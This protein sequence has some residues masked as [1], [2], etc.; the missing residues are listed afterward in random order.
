MKSMRE[1]ER[2]RGR[3]GEGRRSPQ[4]RTQALEG[5]EGHGSRDCCWAF[6]YARAAC[7]LVMLSKV[8]DIPTPRP[9][10]RHRGILAFNAAQSPFDLM[11]A[12]MSHEQGG[13]R[14][15]LDI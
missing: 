9:P 6:F 3:Q 13:A 8:P 11:G 10:W 7:M 14:Q 5:N 4:I 1:R 15:V 2:E 12:H